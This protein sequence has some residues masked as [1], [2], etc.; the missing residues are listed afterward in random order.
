MR[1]DILSLFPGYFQGPFDESIVRR[2]KDAKLVDIQLTNMRDFSLDKHSRVDDTPYGGGPGMV[3][4]SPVVADAINSVKKTDSKVIFL[5][6]QGKTLTAQKCRELAQQSHLILLCGHYEGIDERALKQYVDE[7]ISI[8]DYVL[9]NGCLAA[10]VLVDAVI[11]FVPGV[12]GKQESNIEDS[13]ERY[14][15]DSPHFTKPVEFERIKVP[16]V[17]LQGN[18]K[19]ICTWRHGKSVEKTRHT[20]PDLIDKYML[21]AEKQIHCSS[22]KQHESLLSETLFDKA[23]HIHLV[24]FVSDLT[25]AIRFYRKVFNFSFEVFENEFAYAYWNKNQ[26]QFKLLQTHSDDILNTSPLWIELKMGIH[27]DFSVVQRCL[28]QAKSDY[29]IDKTNKKIYCCDPDKNVWMLD[30]SHTF[31]GEQVEECT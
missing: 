30:F 24:I 2:A 4:K 7:E 15:F 18:H 29:K 14:L 6:P 21:L 27:A 31:Q 19:A 8:G 11:R 1:I 12:L 22:D 3:L 17:L 5:S 10:I 16:E 20:R 23:E 28:K 26:Y 13:F 9:T 25:S